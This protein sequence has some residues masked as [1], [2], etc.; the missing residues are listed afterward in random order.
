MNILVTLL[1]ICLVVTLVY[2]YKKHYTVPVRDAIQPP[3]CSSDIGSDCD[4]APCCP[5]L[6]CIGG[7]CLQ[8]RDVSNVNA[9]AVMS[10]CNICAGMNIPVEAGGDP[11]DYNACLQCGG[12]DPNK[13]Y[14][15]D[16]HM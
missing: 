7:Q 13:L 1:V 8:C 5:G 12:C 3:T 14:D 2:Y 15:I 10:T 9:P 6:Q 16:I 11:K 4:I